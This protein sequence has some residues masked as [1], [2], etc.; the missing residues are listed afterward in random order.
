MTTQSFTQDVSKRSGWGVFMGLVTALIGLVMIMYPFAT[1]NVTTVFLGWSFVFIAVA[2]FVFAFAADG[3]GNFFLKLLLAILYGIVGVTLVSN[4]VQGTST[5]TAVLGAMLLIQAGIEGAFAFD[6]R[7]FSGWGW[8]L[9]DSFVSLALGLM[10][11][12]EWPSSS[13]WAIGTLVGTGVLMNGITRT[14]V[15]AAIHH[16]VGEIAKGTV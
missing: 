8:F 16:D 11:V 6:F 1:A 9:V 13:Q 7:G 12:F 14:V 5:L 2:Q 10:I 15:S 3:V 4:P